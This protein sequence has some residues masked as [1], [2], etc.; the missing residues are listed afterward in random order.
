MPGIR[1]PT[2]YA[3]LPAVNN[4]APPP[5]RPDDPPDPVMAVNV[6]AHPPPDRAFKERELLNVA[7]LVP[8]QASV[9]VLSSNQEVEAS[10]LGN[11]LFSKDIRLSDDAYSAIKGWFDSLYEVA[12]HVPI[13]FS[14]G[15]FL[16]WLS[17][18]RKKF[19]S[20]VIKKWEEVEASIGQEYWAPLRKAR[21][22]T[23]IEKSAKYVTVDGQKPIKPRGISPPSD[24]HKVVCG[25]IISQLYRAMCKFFSFHPGNTSNTIYCSGV[26]TDEIGSCVDEFLDRHPDAIG[27]ALDCSNYDASLELPLQLSYLNYLEKLGFSPGHIR[28]LMETPV[29][30]FTASG[31][32]FKAVSFLGRDKRYY[33]D[34]KAFFD[35]IEWPYKEFE[36]HMEYKTIKMWS[37][38]MDTNLCDSLILTGINE[39]FLDQHHISEY[40][41]LI[42]GDDMFL[43][44]P[45][46]SWSD[47]IFDKLQDWY[48]EFG[49]FPEGTATADRSQWEFCSKLFWWGINP[50]TRREQTVLGPKVGR[51][52][53]RFGYTV[54]IPNETN[55][56]GAALSLRIDAGHVPFV[57]CL[58]QRTYEICRDMKMK[59]KMGRREWEPM[60]A[61]RT[62]ELSKRNYE[63]CEKRYNLSSDMETHFDNQLQTISVI[64]AF[65]SFPNIGEICEVD[66]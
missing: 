11:R 38:R 28:L 35:K 7:G 30:G 63:I 22:F 64:P 48:K 50:E 12:G 45:P 18:Q 51:T 2:G 36:E 59:V 26:S 15:G 37:G 17:A 46:R 27:V 42:C 34:V 66:Q 13:D 44:V 40:L 54:A 3:A 62:F 5:I 31:L 20:T 65:F 32:E 8:Q 21:T 47:V 57:R 4:V 6:V 58:A 39:T 60:H 61:S 49:M 25:P 52:L 23:K 9:N 43:L 29:E 14:R 55:I 33:E 1:I 10:F 24:E 16:S 19:P 41:L 53:A 56:A